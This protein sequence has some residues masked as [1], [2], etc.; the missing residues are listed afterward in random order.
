MTDTNI[1]QPAVETPELAPQED[2]LV[3]DPV[4]DIIT[5]K[6]ASLDAIHDMIQ[7]QD[8]ILK[9][10]YDTYK[11]QYPALFD[12][13]NPNAITKRQIDGLNNLASIKRK[14][15]EV[16]T[17]QNQAIMSV[18]KADAEAQQ[19]YNKIGMDSGLLKTTA[20][21][22]RP[23]YHLLDY[24]YDQGYGR[25][26]SQ[27]QIAEKNPMV[28]I[29]GP[30]G[31]VRDVAKWTTPDE[32]DKMTKNMAVTTTID[33]KTGR[34]TFLIQKDTDI[35]PTIE[36][37]NTKYGAREQTENAFY[38]IGMGVIDGV[39][40]SF[41]QGYNELHSFANDLTNPFNEKEFVN[42][43]GGEFANNHIHTVIKALIANGQ[44][45]AANDLMKSW[46]SNS[47]DLIGLLKKS[48]AL[49][50][51]KQ[52]RELVRSRYG[53]GAWSATDRYIAKMSGSIDSFYAPRAQNWQEQKG[54]VPFMVNNM[55]S[56][57]GILPQIAV[58]ALATAFTGGTAGTATWAKPIATVAK[59]LANVIGTTQAFSE[60][61]KQGR[62]YGIDP[63]KLAMWSMVALPAT[64]LT[65]S[66]TNR[67]WLFR[68]LEPNAF[69]SIFGKAI[70]EH[71]SALFDLQKV[72][73]LTDESVIKSAMRWVGETVGSK[74]AT[75]YLGANS[76]LASSA[77][78]IGSEVVQENSEQA[79][80]NMVQMQLD[81]GT[82]KYAEEGRS[83]YGTESIFDQFVDTTLGTIF[84]TAL[85]SG[86]TSGMPRMIRRA[87]GLPDTHKEEQL[88]NA[89]KWAVLNDKTGDLLNWATGQFNE[90]VFG[91]NKDADFDD[92]F[93]TGSKGENLFV[94]P[95]S[96]H[97]QSLG[98]VEGTPINNMAT[99]RFVEFVQDIENYSN[100]AQ[101]MGLNDIDRA[102][103]G[104]MGF[105]GKA[106]LKT[107]L[108]N[109]IAF[110]DAKKT[111]D[112]VA[113]TN[114][115]SYEQLKNKIASNRELALAGE[116]VIPFTKEEEA[117]LEPYNTYNKA[118]S[119]WQYS[120][121]IEPGT[122]HSQA[123]NDLVKD[124]LT[125]I[126]LV[127]ERL[128][129]LKVIEQM[130][131]EVKNQAD[132][133]FKDE[134]WKAW[135][136]VINSTTYSH[137]K[138]FYQVMK[139][140]G[141]TAQTMRDNALSNMSPFTQEQIATNQSPFRN[142]NAVD[143]NK[144]H[145]TALKSIMKELDAGISD[146]SLIN[147]PEHI[148]SLQG[149]MTEFAGFA[150]ELQQ[151]ATEDNKALHLEDLNQLAQKYSNSYNEIAAKVA[152]LTESGDAL[153][154]DA[155]KQ[156]SITTSDKNA[157][158]MQMAQ[159]LPQIQQGETE[160]DAD[161]N[162]RYKAQEAEYAALNNAEFVDQFANENLALM[163]EAFSA[164]NSFLDNNGEAYALEYKDARKYD[165]LQSIMNDVSKVLKTEQFKEVYK[166][167]EVLDPEKIDTHTEAQE[168][169]FIHKL[170][171]DTEFR[172]KH[173]EALALAQQILEL[174][175][176]AKLVSE[177]EIRKSSMLL[178]DSY[179]QSIDDLIRSQ[180]KDANGNPIKLLTE[181]QEKLFYTV[182]AR[183]VDDDIVKADGKYD[184]ATI[185]KLAKEEQII[186]DTM[187]LLWEQRDILFD[188]SNEDILFEAF[189]ALLSDPVAM[190]QNQTRGPHFL[191]ADDSSA[192]IN[193]DP[194]SS[195]TGTFLTR[196]KFLTVPFSKEINGQKVYI[197][198]GMSNPENVV[199]L[200]Q[201]ANLLLW[202]N[203]K[204]SPASLMAARKTIF[205]AG[206]NVVESGEQ[207]AVVNSVFSFILDKSINGESFIDN[208]VTYI[209]TVRNEE[210]VGMKD[211]FMGNAIAIGGDYGVGKSAVI[212]A[213]VFMLLNILD[214]KT[215]LNIKIISITKELED[216]FKSNLAGLID[217][218]KTEYI[219]FDNFKKSLDKAAVADDNAV[220]IIDESSILN[221]DELRKVREK[222]SGINGA[223]VIY[224]GDMFQMK[225]S[226]NI[227]QLPS[228]NTN[229]FNTH[230]L[231]KQYSTN[232]MLLRKLASGFKESAI[233]G[234]MGK[235]VYID[236]AQEIDQ[237]TG[238]RYGAYYYKSKLEIWNDFTARKDANNAIIF[239]NEAVYNAFKIEHGITST[240][241]QDA[242][243]YYALRNNESTMKMLQGLRR[244]EVYLTYTPLD[245]VDP[246]VK[247]NNNRHTSSAM[248]TGIG[249]ARN[250]VGLMNPTADKDNVVPA[251]AMPT[252]YTT[253]NEETALQLNEYAKSINK[254]RWDNLSFPA[255]GAATD[256]ANA[257]IGAIAKAYTSSNNLTTIEGTDVEYT[258]AMNDAG[259]GI[260]NYT[261]SGKDIKDVKGKASN[262]DF[263]ALESNILSQ[264]EKGK[265]KLELIQPAA[266]APIAITKA[267]AK[268]TARK[269]AAQAKKAAKATPT[270][271]IATV[272]PTVE[273]TEN[274]EY[275]NQTVRIKIT[276]PDKTQS[277]LTYETG[278]TIFIN[279]KS[280]KIQTIG[281]ENVELLS[282]VT[283]TLIT[284][285]KQELLDGD[286]QD[287]TE[288]LEFLIDNKQ[289]DLVMRTNKST[290][291]FRPDQI[292]HW[293]SS[294]TI[295]NPKGNEKGM[296]QEVK[297]RRQF[298]DVLTRNL[299]MFESGV[300]Y[301]LSAVRQSDGSV[302]DS[303]GN[304]LKHNN[305]IV[306]RIRPIPSSGFIS[307]INSLM[308]Y[309]PESTQAQWKSTEGQI[310]SVRISSVFDNN[311]T[312]NKYD[313]G[314]I[315][316]PSVPTF[317]KNGTYQV[318]DGEILSIEPVAAITPENFE[319]LYKEFNAKWQKVLVNKDKSTNAYAALEMQY[320]MNDSLFK[321]RYKDNLNTRVEFKQDSNFK[322][323][324]VPDSKAV[325]LGN[326][327]D[328][329]VTVAMV[330][331]SGA[332]KGHL[333]VT[334]PLDN[335]NEHNIEVKM[336]MLT[337]N[338]ASVVKDLLISERSALDKHMNTGILNDQ[339]Q[340]FDTLMGT[341]LRYLLMNNY[342]N[343][344][345]S[346]KG[347]LNK[348]KESVIFENND[349][350]L[351]KDINGGNQTQTYQDLIDLLVASDISQ[352]Y[353][354]FEK[355]MQTKA[356]K[357]HEAL[358]DIAMNEY[359]T[360]N[361]KRINNTQFY[362]EFEQGVSDDVI[363]SN[364]L[365]NNTDPFAVLEA[366]GIS[367]TAENTIQEMMEE[368]Q[369]M[370][371]SEYVDAYLFL[372]DGLLHMKGEFATGAL[373][374]NQKILIAT[375]NGMVKSSTLRHESFHLIYRNFINDR[376]KA[377][378]VKAV[379]AIA[380]QEDIRIAGSEEEWMAGDYG[381]NKVRNMV[382]AKTQLENQYNQ[383]VGL[384]NR[385]KAFMKLLIPKFD[386][387]Y[388]ANSRLNAIYDSISKG[389]FKDRLT[390]IVVVKG[391]TALEQASED[392]MEESQTTDTI[393]YD[394]VDG[395][396]VTQLLTEEVIQDSVVKAA[397]NISNLKANVLLNAASYS[398]HARNV[399]FT[400]I[401][402]S[403]FSN[404]LQNTDQFNLSDAITNIKA[405]YQKTH[406]QV[407]SIEIDLYGGITG[408]IAGL[409][410]SNPDGLK[411]IQSGRII[412]ANG[413]ITF[414]DNVARLKYFV[415][416]YTLTS[417]DNLLDTVQTLL[418]K[419]DILNDSSSDVVGNTMSLDW[420][421]SS[422]D[423]SISQI[424]QLMLR[425]VPRINAD[426]FVANKGNEMR[427]FDQN[428][429]KSVLTSVG[430][431]TNGA[432]NNMMRQQSSGIEVDIPDMFTAFQQVMREIIDNGKTIREQTD[433][434]SYNVYQDEFTQA[435]HGIYNMLF[436]SYGKSPNYRLNYSNLYASNQNT[437]FVGLSEKAGLLADQIVDDI[438]SQSNTDITA[439]QKLVLD[440]QNKVTSFVS[441]FTS[442]KV[443]DHV[444][445]ELFYNAEHEMTMKSVHMQAEGFLAVGQQ[446]SDNI[447]G[448]TPGHQISRN[449]KTFINDKVS[450]NVIAKDKFIAIDGER[451]MHYS[452][453]NN[454]FVL[455]DDSG[456][457]MDDKNSKKPFDARNMKT[458]FKAYRTFGDKIGLNKINQK[459][460][461][462]IMTSRWDEVSNA[463]ESMIGNDNYKKHHLT[464]IRKNYKTPGAFMI[465][466]MGSLFTMLQLYNT[467]YVA[468]GSNTEKSLIDFININKRTPQ[469][470][471]TES[472]MTLKI[473]STILDNFFKN[474]EG[475]TKLKD[476]TIKAEAKDVQGNAEE[477]D[478]VAERFVS[479]KD[480]WVAHNAIG[481]M[482]YK[483]YGITSDRSHASGTGG[484]M[485]NVQLTSQLEDILEEGAQ[486]RGFTIDKVETFIGLRRNLG[487]T[488]IGKN[489]IDTTD[490]VY[491]S[492]NM[493]MQE[494]FNGS[495]E[496]QLY[497]PLTTVSDTGKIQY[498]Q[499]RSAFVKMNNGVMTIDYK[500]VGK[501]FV[502]TYRAYNDR[503]Q[504][505]REEF[506][507]VIENINALS[508]DFNVLR[509]PYSKI[510]DAKHAARVN[511]HYK[512]LNTS[513]EQLLITAKEKG[514][515]GQ[516]K[517]IIDASKL[518]KDFS[519]GGNF[520]ISYSTN[521]QGELQ[522]LKVGKMITRSVDQMGYMN[523]H[524]KQ[525]SK[526]EDSLITLSSIG[527]LEQNQ[528]TKAYDKAMRDM[529]NAINTLTRKEF[530]KF[531]TLLALVGFKKGKSL[532]RLSE[533]ANKALPENRRM[534]NA[535]M[536]YEVNSSKRL[537]HNV[538]LYAFFLGTTMLNNSI[539]EVGMDP[540]SF[541]SYENK[542]KRNG[543]Y[544]TPSQKML[545]GQKDS[546]GRYIGALEPTNPIMYY[547]D[548]I[549]Q[550]EMG[551]KIY[552]VKK[553]NG[554]SYINPLYFRA[555]KMSIGGTD[556]VMG[557]STMLKTITTQ[558]RKIQMNDGRVINGTTSQIKLAE[559]A[560]TNFDFA[561][562][563][564]RNMIF[565]MLADSDYFI[566]EELQRQADL[567]GVELPS[568]SLSAMFEEIF[569]E[570][571]EKD[572]DKVFDKMFQNIIDLQNEPNGTILYK[573]VMG[574][575]VAS[576]NPTETQ[577]G[578]HTI[579]N[580]YNP[581]TDIDHGIPLNYDMIQNEQRRFILNPSDVTDNSKPQAAPNQ[582][583]LFYGVTDS[584]A[585]QAISEQIRQLRQEMQERSTT[586]LV[587]EISA[588]NPKKYPVKFKDIDF[589]TLDMETASRD[590]LAKVDAALLQLAEYLRNKNIKDL[591]I[592]Q[593]E[594]AYIQ[595]MANKDV[596]IQLPQ[597]RSKLILSYR[598]LINK[599]I[600]A[601]TSGSRF[602][603]ASGDF[604]QYYTKDGIS[605]DLFEAAKVSG[606][607]M[608]SVTVADMKANTLEN[609]IAEQGWT[610]Q[611]LTDMYVDE[612][613]QTQAGTVVIPN[614]YAGIYGHKATETLYDINTLQFN[615][616]KRFDIS[617]VSLPSEAVHTLM[618][619]TFVNEIDGKERKMLDHIN[620]LMQH[621]KVEFFT[622]LFNS[623]MVRKAI[624]NL[625][626]NGVQNLFDNMKEVDMPEFVSQTEIQRRA[627]DRHKDGYTKQ[628][629]DALAVEVANMSRI[630][631]EQ[632]LKAITTEAHEL[633][634]VF[635]EGIQLMISRVPAN[636]IGSGGVYNTVMFH[637][638]G[639]VVYIPSKMTL[640]NDSD[641]DID[642]LTA[643]MDKIGKRGKYTGD[644]LDIANNQMNRLRNAIYMNKDSQANVFAMAPTGSLTDTLKVK[645]KE[646]QDKNRQ[647]EPM[648]NNTP[649]AIFQTYLQNKAGADSIGI[650]SNSLNV[651]ALLFSNIHNMNKENNILVARKNGT[652]YNML[653]SPLNSY[654][655]D[656][657]RVP[658]IGGEGIIIRTG[659]WQQA[660]LD[661]AKINILGR[662]NLSTNSINIL[663]IL[664]SQGKT[665][666]EIYDFF[667]NKI[668]SNLLHEY[669]K[670]S[671]IQTKTSDYDMYIMATKEYEK[672]KGKYEKA[673]LT[674]TE[675]L[676]P[677]QEIDR[678]IRSITNLHET[679]A[680]NVDLNLAKL[681]LTRDAKL[682]E[683]THS[684]GTNVAYAFTDE[685]AKS[686][687]SDTLT[688]EIKTKVQELRVEIAAGND[689]SITDTIMSHE[690]TVD[691]EGQITYF[692]EAVKKR[693]DDIVK[694][695]TSE[696]ELQNMLDLNDSVNTLKELPSITITAEA[697]YRIAK[698]LKMR[699]G[700]PALDA[701]Y[702]RN[703]ND[704]EQMLGMSL[705]DYVA[706]DTANV[707]RKE[708]DPSQVQK[709]MEFYEANNDEYN[710]LI[711]GN[712]EDQLKAVMLHRK[713]EL[714]ASEINLPIL[715][716]G[717]PQINHIVG[718]LYKLD[719]MTGRMF[720]YDSSVIFDIVDRFLALQNR[721]AINY[722]NEYSTVMEAFTKLTL[723]KFYADEKTTIDGMTSPYLVSD[724]VWNIKRDLATKLN[725]AST[726][727]RDV[728]VGL[729]PQ[730]I[731]DLQSNLDSTEY[732]EKLTGETDQSKLIRLK[733]NKFLQKVRKSGS[734]YE[735]LY[736]ETNTKKLTEQEIDEY[737]NEFKDMPQMLQDMFQNYEIIKNIMS[738]RK[739]GI[740][741][742]M[743][744]EFYSGNISKTFESVHK[745]LND[746]GNI[747]AFRGEQVS[748]SSE[749][750][751]NLIDDVEQMLFDYLGFQPVFQKFVPYSEIE[752]YKP[753]RP[754][755]AYSQE[756]L[757]M[758]QQMMGSRADR[759]VSYKLE[760][761]TYYETH[762]GSKYGMA[763]SLDFGT[764]TST[765]EQLTELHTLGYST[766]YNKPVGVAVGQAWYTGNKKMVTV[767]HVDNTSFTFTSVAEND[768]Q[769]YIAEERKRQQEKY[770]TVDIDNVGIGNENI[771][772]VTVYN[773]NEESTA[774]QGDLDYSFN[775]DDFASTVLPV[776]LGG[777]EPVLAP[778]KGRSVST[779][780]EMIDMF[781]WGV[782]S[783]I[784]SKNKDGKLI[785][786]YNSISDLDSRKK[787]IAKVIWGL[788]DDIVTLKKRLENQVGDKQIA[789][790]Q[791]EIEQIQIAVAALYEL[792]PTFVKELLMNRTQKFIDNN[793]NGKQLVKDMFDTDQQ[794]L[795]GGNE[796]IK[797][798]SHKYGDIV[799]WSRMQLNG[800]VNQTELTK[801]AK[802][803]NRAQAIAL[804]GESKFIQQKMKAKTTAKSVEVA[805]LQQVVANAAQ[806]EIGLTMALDNLAYKTADGNYW[807]RQSAVKDYAKSW[808]NIKGGPR[809]L[810]IN[811]A[812]KPK[813][814][815]F[816]IGDIEDTFSR[817]YIEDYVEHINN[818]GNPDSYVFM[819]TDDELIGYM[820]NKSVD[821]TSMEAVVKGHL[822]DLFKVFPIGK[823]KLEV[824]TAP[825]LL[826][827]GSKSDNINES[828]KVYK[829][830]QDS[831]GN[832]INVAPYTDEQGNEIIFAGYA[833]KPDMVVFATPIGNTEGLATVKIL[834]DSKT[835]K[836]DIKRNEYFADYAMQLMNINAAMKFTEGFNFDAFLIMGAEKYVE[837]GVTKFKKPNFNSKEELMQFIRLDKTGD[838][839]HDKKIDELKVKVATFADLTGIG[840]GKHNVYQYM[841]NM[842]NDKTDLNNC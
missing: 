711:V 725:L 673:P 501:H 739:N 530:E 128:K 169:Q 328:V 486:M 669:D 558:R 834:I 461:E 705:R 268:A 570:Q 676:F 594:L 458:L 503:V 308:K 82:S 48:E 232:S 178:Q 297:D 333:Y 111:F 143:L 597:M 318:K 76:F 83:K 202:L 540:F 114:K 548:N 204:H 229:I 589:T 389:E 660:A 787:Y 467:N 219:L 496:P 60:F 331:R 19:T 245:Y 99:M 242:K 509:A 213:R 400:I 667:S 9:G 762:R 249:R 131:P 753:Y 7:S 544:N 619:S 468:E 648:Q 818:G 133:A 495:S 303:K 45:A 100:L 67:I 710:Q 276:H 502:D 469:V 623:P 341:H 588:T 65:E 105:E 179:R 809:S 442:N 189:T 347:I 527:T 162:A 208:L 552:D 338:Y 322:R 614:V 278:D 224:M 795:I 484:Q 118:M 424:Q 5:G 800:N 56:F 537:N 581:E 759:K 92:A 15:D 727:D 49:I 516:V 483:I 538:P 129:D 663:S 292:V 677:N 628:D 551:G 64:Y 282:G 798:G 175:P 651:S 392:A 480:F 505:S 260:I 55:E 94:V 98:M 687:M 786:T 291:Q 269:A 449:L 564:G 214:S 459:A 113:E 377:E 815:S 284:M 702:R 647:A 210:L 637:N 398:A 196:S 243:V 426:G 225:N 696:S 163:K 632:V 706:Y 678:N 4:A 24:K 817:H 85:L 779:V 841:S 373:V 421:N 758:Q 149:A 653:T 456:L 452:N 616:G 716:K 262:S 325:K 778:F 323:N 765:A 580:T 317:D 351:R 74:G 624:D 730:L 717:I 563:S 744:L 777:L 513:L 255:Q 40:K 781:N 181:E 583:E 170:A 188:K 766:S 434:V 134:Y 183:T 532:I 357:P 719:N 326:I 300:D 598:N 531:S 20:S 301:E 709:H 110:Q 279:K 767:T 621:Q 59:I 455:I 62:E 802:F 512:A 361:T 714:V 157:L 515:L 403:P 215:K 38:A 346:T 728:F 53:E 116:V 821:F 692:S 201:H 436:G 409:S 356:F 142:K 701:D 423:T 130:T 599:T 150:N 379:R 18:Y 337:G 342:A 309:M 430:A 602:V 413:A 231:T 251:Q 270:S 138:S 91:N 166:V 158:S 66:L 362:V 109:Y 722:G 737:R 310:D 155:D 471:D 799:R 218:H 774:K 784:P 261:I 97:L 796:D 577:K 78:M 141:N 590:E 212:M 553:D 690:G 726:Y 35:I 526:I 561:H 574:S 16:M 720:T 814:Q 435:V 523:S 820:N 748:L 747:L 507:R 585:V 631:T 618:N 433:T 410:K 195:D 120:T 465:D 661:N 122:K 571:T 205:E 842:M 804:F 401:Q 827:N 349:I 125:Y 84:V 43:D 222:L 587:Q 407:G 358:G 742:I 320:K 521:E 608:A 239:L 593:N 606:Y 768:Q 826:M 536:Y 112:E 117:T 396:S 492:I 230:L 559:H 390:D 427:Y 655:K 769:K 144:K 429:V 154:S 34:P 386:K 334:Y 148:R 770:N 168:R 807:L 182:D 253:M 466:Y 685:Q 107:T 70:K 283:K 715:F 755:Y 491:G 250:W 700:V 782:L 397:T 813:S 393:E 306:L 504:A 487:F 792:K 600:Q 280:Y 462:T 22:M 137:L 622:K 567:L 438:Y 311:I 295:H 383:A 812:V 607:D 223:K 642:A 582:A 446:M 36:R 420:S 375:I 173:N 763:D 569:N 28:K 380:S 365:D 517:N 641:F 247:M 57:G 643:Y 591:S 119:E 565:R 640:R 237:A 428:Y 724:N 838:K 840:F 21:S 613:G 139:E 217:N 95:A 601:R 788:G 316:D 366:V 246:N 391:E 751:A 609:Y 603:Q 147:K 296:K 382:E 368:A 238:K 605:L 384:W 498:A 31:K 457:V 42:R 336:P 659:I 518:S 274:D 835:M 440:I 453:R 450:Y 207:E 463:F 664:I 772:R 371:G 359:L 185:V 405:H 254:I 529:E 816:L 791:N 132:Q 46:E 808:K 652:L 464:D 703:I 63:E 275:A 75:K 476:L 806:R 192:H 819:T 126:K 708:I 266:Q 140:S 454:R 244:D 184:D 258:I 314:S 572:I 1:T 41:A 332:S 508:S 520:D 566:G 312:D 187:T 385:F 550:H 541:S 441:V 675:S 37:Y 376:A 533:Q 399:G 691:D 329:D 206:G 431:M 437:E 432:I 17:T 425:S 71:L 510:M 485:Q 101:N 121:A 477:Y 177:A 489:K 721:R 151:Q 775:V 699:S 54:F 412:G 776:T 617:K 694:L 557:N 191:T 156:M 87:K 534:K 387:V 732:I 736:F 10:T 547:H 108:D 209:N 743:G 490:Y 402:N 626:L 115:V 615:D 265:I 713:E 103:L 823:Y 794:K 372:N 665:Q 324:Y 500:E 61:H 752:S 330:N 679:I 666:G 199:R 575:M 211:I 203:S 542:V 761:G 793:E 50:P 499:T 293:S 731:S 833:T 197:H 354:Y 335:N 257:S 535:K 832:D 419:Y 39:S 221:K 475:V 294:A 810:I 135:E 568:V 670:R 636:F 494:L 241:E 233:K 555:T 281:N 658:I 174:S 422:L 749:E 545:I 562:Q 629:L 549:V 267:Q 304:T 52:G 738:F 644:K 481:S 754:V 734:N 635:N 313:I 511:A 829:A 473:G 72:G 472:I 73:K 81:K 733:N 474:T 682:K 707:Q 319:A 227:T 68:H 364:I 633:T 639:N 299:S 58:S 374:D 350:R 271:P 478:T 418:P 180:F 824:T 764:F 625:Q 136:H 654:M 712:K 360:T 186:V 3:I 830:E 612:Q 528:K 290:L 123:V 315:S 159:S 746:Y 789:K 273:P 344:V 801:V 153:L 264:I 586:K 370:L 145:D 576:Y 90:G 80:Y 200:K 447:D 584:G 620:S 460:F 165:N 514:L 573:T 604:I 610:E 124:Q 674:V 259:N 11:A 2:K 684:K 693:F 345:A 539:D 235:M 69:D 546:R 343:I 234:K 723:N 837:E 27:E 525:L 88:Q 252:G 579:T 408:T 680:Y 160:S 287:A 611:R 627:Q 198:S 33:E 797:V 683:K 650:L 416:I 689:N 263:K 828:F 771:N 348:I 321:L 444:L 686:I 672:S 106:T 363:V 302:L 369:K 89:R 506:D 497:F 414:I 656:G 277:E 595:M 729:F 785:A 8:E 51:I 519:G 543:P 404:I 240:P 146:G 596:S 47:P 415:D 30:D 783:T 524:V 388:R 439:K 93:V 488:H 289:D 32:M 340:Y 190:S 479:G 216:S 822:D 831:Q 522:D 805:S 657:N 298:Q 704:L 226:D 825:M 194:L 470:R 811:G 556:T 355:D 161:F 96:E 697:Y 286:I 307:K 638:G 417:E 86:F 327:L 395:S 735:T 171:T 634:R 836:P 14:A 671:S 127:E 12:A 25:Y 378:L 681:I 750:Q 773:Y 13:N 698:V 493:F 645:E 152:Q 79:I 381:N 339:N 451:I 411:N 668:I 839:V 448:L 367:K 695:M 445:Q 164:L 560:L 104:Q 228:V 741:Q 353:D 482:L 646:Y 172:E 688:D 592:S 790:V 23:T 44:G 102:V 272:E 662:F 740:T 757:T 760:D 77:V 29:E 193:K 803:N 248:Y 288:L 6:E 443:K 305:L 256:A 176:E 167:A 780:S 406:D 394:E 745:A 756:P 220:Y 630:N 285:T 26:A 718:E 554:M 578:A 352:M 236:V 649:T